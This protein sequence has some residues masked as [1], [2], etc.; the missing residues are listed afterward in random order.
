M[1]FHSMSELKAYL[2][3]KMEKA[4]IRERDSVYSVINMYL[5]QFYE[6]YDPNEY[7]RTEQLLRSLVKSEIKQEANGFSAYVYFDI[8]GLDYALH[9]ASWTK[10]MNRTVA[11][12]ALTGKKG[13]APA[14]SVKHGYKYPHGG[15][16]IAKRKRGVHQTK[17]W[18]ESLKTLEGSTGALLTMLNMYGI[19]CRRKG[20]IQGIYGRYNDI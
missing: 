17:I 6:E 9:R 18:I 7:H 2:M 10:E 16:N 14:I 13:D 3:P 20:R 19:P 11:N 8:D 4:L 1:A 15:Y 12:I 5:K